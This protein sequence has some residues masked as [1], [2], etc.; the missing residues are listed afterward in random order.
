[1]PARPCRLPPISG[2]QS[3]ATNGIFNG[4]NVGGVD[5]SSDADGAITVIDQAIDRCLHRS[6]DVGC[7]SES[8]GAHCGES[9]CCC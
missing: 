4:H 7:Y 9:E 2:S 5:V 1:M 8:S 3:P 6:F